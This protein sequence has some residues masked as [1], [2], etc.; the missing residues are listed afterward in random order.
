MRIFAVLSVLPLSVKALA[1]TIH[2]PA[3]FPAIQAAIDAAAGGDTVLVAPGEY[4]ISEPI[5]F[6]GKAISVLSDAGPDATIIRMSPAPVDPARASVVVF[7]G[8]EPREAALAGFTLTGGVGARWSHV[9]QAGGGIHFTNASSPTISRCRIAG[10]SAAGGGG[11]VFSHDSAPTLRNCLIENNE[12]PEG[13]A[14]YCRHSY[15]SL[16]NCTIAG[17]I[18]TGLSSGPGN[19]IL[20]SDDTTIPLVNSIVWDNAPNS[21]AGDIAS[22]HSLIDQDPRFADPAGGDYRLL[23]QSPAI[24]AGTA[25]GAPT[26]DL[27][28]SGRPCGTG[29]DLGAFESGDCARPEAVTLVIEVSPPGAG[30]TDP[31]SGSYTFRQ[32]GTVTVKAE[33]NP[34]YV[35]L[36]WAIVPEEPLVSHLSP[37][38]SLRMEEGIILTR[39]TAHFSGQDFLRGD[40]N[41]DLGTDISDVVGVLDHLF[42]GLSI[43]CLAAA[44]ATD[45]GTV[46]ISDPIRMLGNLF[47]GAPPLP[48]PSTRCGQDPTGD[49]L[50]CDSSSCP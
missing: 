12:A 8:G 10:N 1:G 30:V 2:V 3:D 49:Q 35:F 11:G 39:L 44:D 40:A 29:V 14:V 5:T 27:S 31:P 33:S 18:A 24:D 28:G 50:P 23:P 9:G 42:L 15:L 32:P 25:D 46:D 16:V 13:A 22:V 38:I 41:S 36:G 6:Q 43:A 4:R 17:N 26:E 20:G 21:T 19:A 48:P 45:D 37:E 7:E 47:L 34:G